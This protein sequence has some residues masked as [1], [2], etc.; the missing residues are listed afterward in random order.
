M[1]INNSIKD[2]YHTKKHP[3]KYLISY[4]SEYRGNIIYGYEITKDPVEWIAS[5]QEFPETYILLNSQLI[6]DIQVKKYDYEFKGM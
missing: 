6:T 3:K 5:V 2:F 1:T 4:R